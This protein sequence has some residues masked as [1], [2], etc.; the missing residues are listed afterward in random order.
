MVMGSQSAQSGNNAIHVW[1]AGDSVSV[2]CVRLGEAESWMRK[3]RQV[4]GPQREEALSVGN[5]LRARLRE[6]DRTP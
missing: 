4:A 5:F 3:T 2:E 1:L 6:P